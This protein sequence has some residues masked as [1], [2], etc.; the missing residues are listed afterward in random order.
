LSKTTTKPVNINQYLTKDT[1]TIYLYKD[2]SPY[3]Y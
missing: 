2:F 3:I 1:N